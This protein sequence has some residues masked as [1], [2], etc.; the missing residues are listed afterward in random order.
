MSN[1]RTFARAF[2]STIYDSLEVATHMADFRQ[3]P[4]PRLRTVLWNAGWAVGIWA[5]HYAASYLPRSVRQTY[6]RTRQILAAPVA[7]TQHKRRAIEIENNSP[8]NQPSPDQPSTVQPSPILESEVAGNEE[9]EIDISLDI[10]LTDIRTSTPP[11][12]KSN[13]LPLHIN[14]TSPSV[15]APSPLRP[16]GE[17]LLNEQLR[18]TTKLSCEL[19]DNLSPARD[20]IYTPSPPTIDSPSIQNII[21]SSSPI[22]DSSPLQ[23]ITSSPRFSDGDASPFGS[24]NSSPFQS[25]VGSPCPSPS[26]RGYDNDLSFLDDASPLP[27]RRT[28]RWTRDACVKPFYYDEKVDEML[29]STLESINFSPVKREEIFEEDLVESEVSEELLQNLHAA[30]EENNTTLEAN[31]YSEPKALVSP[32]DLPEIEY[33]DSIVDASDGGQNVDYSIVDG[34]LNVRDFA[35]LLP[36]LFN[37]DPRAWLNDNVV[38]EYLAILVDYCKRNAGFEHNRGGPAPPVHAF[39]SFWYTS[40]KK[41]VESVRRWASRFQLAGAQYLD[42]E[43]IFYPICDAGH[44]RLIAVKPKARSIEYLDSLGFNGK[45]YTD[46]LLEYLKMELKDDF[47]AEE[48]TVS[49]TQRSSRQMNGSDCGVFTLLNALALMRGEDADRV[50]ACDGMEDARLR[51]AT[52]LMAGCPTTEMD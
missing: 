44:W 13:G 51:I 20:I 25:E 33:L 21:K 1:K 9:E 45:P 46:K 24:N 23:I 4:R 12:N 49:Q 31:N 8:P 28:V 26:P 14:W 15:Y 50:I 10:S 19:A 52:T 11:Q 48:W 47:V 41:S 27:R 36:G 22:F 40:A 29:D 43:L 16:F 2:A 37:G 5:V 17:D 7:G 38:N 18:P 34:K 32:L 3:S 42:A 30:A 6:A 39:S 35:T